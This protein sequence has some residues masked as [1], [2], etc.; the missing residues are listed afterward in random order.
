MAFSET[1]QPAGSCDREEHIRHRGGLDLRVDE[2]IESLILGG[3]SPLTIEGYKA[4]LKRLVDYLI[5][6]GIEETEQ[7]T[8]AV[9]RA[10]LE[11]MRKTH[12]LDQATI[13]K[14]LMTLKAFWRWMTAEKHC[15]SD[16]CL[17]VKEKNPKKIVRGLSPDKM[18]MVLALSLD[19]SSQGVRNVA[20]IRAFLDSAGRVS[21]VVKLEL[22][23][24]DLEEGTLK[25]KGKNNKERLVPIGEETRTALRRYLK[26]RVCQNSW[27]WVNRRG[28]RL[29]RSGVQQML[30]KLRR[31]LGFHLHP[32]LLRHT[33]AIAFHRNGGTP[34]ELQHI[35]GHTT[36]EMTRRYCQ[37]L[38]D[39]DICRKHKLASPVDN[40]MRARSVSCGK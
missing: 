2:Y 30:R 8:P 26:Q 7:I 32:H 21:E 19:G 33:S 15:G 25:L 12:H 31:E 20:L 23:D 3:R 34:F 40:G 4:K 14:Y 10:F 22:Q 13:Y 5:Q 36:L 1:S 35:L 17:K 37:A 29:T 11:Y 16:P 27:L 38:D 6:E 24:V 28:G 39:E 9:I 18:T